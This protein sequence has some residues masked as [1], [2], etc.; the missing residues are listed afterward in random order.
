MLFLG[1][2]VSDSE[3]FIDFPVTTSDVELVKIL[4]LVV[5]SDGVERIFDLEYHGAKRAHGR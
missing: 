1:L 5:P 4:L 3:V 2:F